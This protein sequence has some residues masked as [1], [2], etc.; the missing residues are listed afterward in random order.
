MLILNDPGDDFSRLIQGP[1]WPRRRAPK[2]LRKYG[3]AG[4]LGRLGRGSCHGRSAPA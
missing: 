3:P 2:G 4:G 1:A